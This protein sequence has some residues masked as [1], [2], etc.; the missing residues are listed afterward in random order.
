MRG[1]ELAELAHGAVDLAVELGFVAGEA[2]GGF[3]VRESGLELG[4]LAP[5]GEGLLAL[6]G[7]ECALGDFEDE[8]VG[9]ALAAGA[10]DDEEGA[11][12]G[13]VDG[14]GSEGG[15]EH[16]DGRVG[17]GRTEVVVAA[18]GVVAARDS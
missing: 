9:V 16:G 11:Q 1:L 15:G 10:R 4:D 14:V 3:G 5:A 8:V 12:G 13:I 18:D 17:L 6:E 7:F 2:L